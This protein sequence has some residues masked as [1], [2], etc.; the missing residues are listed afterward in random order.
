MK[1]DNTQIA[2]FFFS[3]LLSSLS[4]PFICKLLCRA[5]TYKEDA[6]I[7]AV[8]NKKHLFSFSCGCQTSFLCADECMRLKKEKKRKTIKNSSFPF[9][10]GIGA[11]SHEGSSSSSSKK[12]TRM[13]TILIPRTCDD[14]G[15]KKK[16][17]QPHMSLLAAL[18]F[19]ILTCFKRVATYAW[20]NFSM[21]PEHASEVLSLMPG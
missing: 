11:F 12:R 9:S 19:C 2:Y 14:S 13:Q 4:P 20:L 18:L 5:S 1:V 15:Q 3:W 17:T 21:A 7:E 6:L 10:H 16:K 8:T